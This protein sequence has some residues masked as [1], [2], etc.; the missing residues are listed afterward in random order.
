MTKK[1]ATLTFISEPLDELLTSAHYPRLSPV[2][3]GTM[4]LSTAIHW[5]ATEGLKREFKLITA[6]PT[7]LAAGVALRD[8]IISE[9]AL[10]Y[11]ENQDGEY[12]QIPAIDYINKDLT[13]D[14]EAGVEDIARR[15]NRIEIGLSDDG[16]CLF[17]A[18]SFRAIFTKIVVRKEDILREWPFDNSAPLRVKAVRGKKPL[19]KE[20]L[21]RHF[22]GPV[23]SPAFENR[24]GLKGK[25]E[26]S[27]LATQHP[28]LK[29]IDDGT[30]KTAIDEHN[31]EILQ[32]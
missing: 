16:D 21:R 22:T 31:A 20:Y 25:I 23:P 12:E 2:G 28:E 6:G 29:S 11:G 1:R 7:Y 17:R 13:F 9:N 5:I 15:D 27:E 24:K 4:P 19:I 3:D 10:T 8:K 32:T 18:N 14:F 30:L 26:N